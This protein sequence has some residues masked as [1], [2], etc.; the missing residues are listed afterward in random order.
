MPPDAHTGRIRFTEQGEV[1]SFRYALTDIARRHLEQIVH[2]QTV[3]LVGDG[4]EERVEATED[5]LEGLFQDL[6][7]RSMAAYRAL[8]DSPGF[9]PWYINATPVAAIG[10]LPLASRPVSRKKGAGLDFDGLRAI[11]WVFAWTQTRYTVPGWYGLGTALDA[12][13]DRLD[14]MRR[15]YRTW[16]F[17]RAV[18]DNAQRE[19]ARAR[20]PIARA[21]SRLAKDADADDVDQTVRDEFE[22][23]RRAILQITG[24][25]VL[26]EMSPV[27]RRSIRMRNP[28]TDALNLLQIDLLKRRGSPS[29]P[30]DDLIRALYVSIN[31]IA[32]AMQSTG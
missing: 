15:A 1:I 17:F 6:A 28:F 5:D 30:A 12:A 11:P 8:I 13:S 16:P 32:A 26:L 19:M 29:S 25:D 3:A 31:G 27:I 18:I 22:R 2:A 4:T 20:L 24:Q 23:T 14:D 9:W 7:E 10:D 21:Y